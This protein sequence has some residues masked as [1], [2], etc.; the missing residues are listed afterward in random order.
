MGVLADVGEGLPDGGEQVL[1][2]EVVD[3]GVQ[4]AGERQLH[5]E[6]DDLVELAHEGG[7]V[8][9]DAP[10]LVAHPELVDRGAHLRND[11][12]DLRHGDA[13][14]ARRGVGHAGGHALEGETEREEPLDDRVMEVPGHAVAVFVD[15]RTAHP[16]MEAGVLDRDARRQR[17]RPHQRL[18]VE[19]ELRP[20][21][22][23]CQIEVP[24][25]LVAH[26]DR[27]AEKG[28]H[29]RVVGREAEA[30]GMA[31]DLVDAQRAR[32][33]DEQPE[34]PTA[35]RARTDLVLL[36]FG[37]PDGD[38][39]RQSLFLFVEDPERPVARPGHGARLLDD[40]P[41]D[42]GQFQVRLDQQRRLE[43]P[44]EL[45]WILDPTKRHDAEPTHAPSS[46][47]SCE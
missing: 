38:E 6:A 45:A 17:E 14:L 40:V 16:V 42:L 47:L 34:D 15:R 32:V 43:H 9:A 11:A 23:V 36:L 22:L 30:V 12:V 24:V 31:A 13:E 35:R 19:G 26:L 29:G 1:E 7:D 44:P 18:V 8:V 20:P 3:G 10:A 39:F 41:E 2:D 27:H 21:H 46:P 28:R 33:G 5:L 37:E 25:H 4:R